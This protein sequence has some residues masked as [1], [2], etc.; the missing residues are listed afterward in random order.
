[1]EG[2]SQNWIEGEIGGYRVMVG[3]SAQANDDLTFGVG[4]PK[5]LWFHVAGHP[6]SHVVV[7]VPKGNDEVPFEVVERAVCDPAIGPE[8]LIFGTDTPAPYTYYKYRG[9]FYPSYGKS[10]PPFFPD[11]YKH[12][13][14]N[15]ERLHI[16]DREKEMILGGNI[17]SILGL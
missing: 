15:I 3:R 9:E 16:P 11:H 8:K 6:G 5:D 10:P 7:R 17:A 13:L 14:A 12:D 4:S 1:M 2:T